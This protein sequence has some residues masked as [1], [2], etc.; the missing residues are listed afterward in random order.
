M[1]RTT[2]PTAEHIQEGNRCFVALMGH[3]YLV[4]ILRVHEDRIR[5]S[6]PVSDFPVDGMRAVLEFHSPDAVTTYES[7]VLQRPREVDD[8]MVLARP[9]G[10]TRMRHRGSWR[11]PTSLKG[12]L[13]S[14]VHPRRHDCTVGNL[15]AGGALV[16][17][18]EEIEVVT[19]DD[20]E[21]MFGLP[22]RPD[23]TFTGQVVHI[24][25]PT[26]DPRAE[27]ILGVEFISPD[28]GDLRE[29]RGYLWER[30]REIDPEGASYLRQ[31]ADLPGIEEE[32][33]L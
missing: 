33:R 3:R 19:G 10:R 13:R 11:V 21:L 29:V 30:M 15:S 16:L 8:G 25:D 17:L 2:D 4:S 12:K 6:F 23:K 28:P 9:H 14:H 31:R 24:V 32:P 20:V 1:A 5:V 27:M 22:H 18:P 26:G 7:E